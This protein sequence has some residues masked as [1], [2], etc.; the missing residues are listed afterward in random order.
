VLTSRH[1]NLFIPAICSLHPVPALQLILRI[2]HVL[3]HMRPVKIIQPTIDMYM[4]TSKRFCSIVQKSESWIDTH[5]HTHTHT[6]IHIHKHTHTHTHT[7]R[8]RERER[9]RGQTFLCT[10]CVCA[11]HYTSCVNGFIILQTHLPP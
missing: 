8:E 10:T 4:H 2:V 6:H 5:T 3:L 1:I 11:E 9:E 7:Q